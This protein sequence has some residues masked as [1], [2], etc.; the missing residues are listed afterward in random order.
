MY[1]LGA[2][3]LVP[4]TIGVLMV[5]SSASRNDHAN[6]ISRDVA[7]MYA[8]G[9]DFSNPAN[10]NIALNV[11][12]GLGVDIRAGRGVLILSRLRVV[13]E[14]DCGANGGENC[15]NKG[16]AVVTQRFIIGNSAL[17]GSSFG[18]PNSIDP[19]TGAVRNWAGD[20][21]ARAVDFPTTLKAG[22]STFAAEC[23]LA[24]SEAGNGIYSRAMF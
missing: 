6:Q 19:R 5:S 17:R 2:I 13:H 7:S 23:Y 14:S 16:Y 22:E 3:F 21:T 15:A 8:Q 1:A 12:G 20:V 9:V 18:S 10:Q 4:L 24:S 11:A